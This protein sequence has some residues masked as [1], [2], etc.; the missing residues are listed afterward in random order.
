MNTKEK[1]RKKIKKKRKMMTEKEWEE[2]SLII[3]NKFLINSCWKNYSCFLCYF[4]FDKEVKTDII[5]KHLLAHGKVVCIPKIDWDNKFFIPTR[6]FS[7]SDIDLNR[8]I[9]EPK[10]VDAI[11]C[12]LIDLSITPGVAFN[13]YGE[14]I[15]MGGGFYDK[16][17]SSFSNIF[18][19]SLAFDFQVLEY[20]FPVDKHDSKID[21]IITE[22]RVIIT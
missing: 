9:P 22:K 8:K 15:G 16:F 21:L 2:K 14:R 12:E 13:I 5:I 11:P 7:I 3:Q 1:I 10:N 20:K 4:H 18:K 19:V 17:F 6:I